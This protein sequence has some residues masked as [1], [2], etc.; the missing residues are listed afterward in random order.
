VEKRVLGEETPFEHFGG[1][2]NR[3]DLDVL[4]EGLASTPRRRSLKV[5]A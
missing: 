1:I 4:G 3:R 5:D 2:V